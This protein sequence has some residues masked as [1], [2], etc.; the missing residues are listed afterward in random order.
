MPDKA[1]RLPPT[2]GGRTGTEMSALR[3]WAFL[4]KH[5]QV[6]LA[7]AKRPGSTVSDLA[8]ATEIT[9]RS[10]Y[11]VLADLQRSG[12]I[13]RR[14]MGRHN[15]YEIDPTMPLLDPTVENEH[16]RDLLK[17]TDDETFEARLFRLVSA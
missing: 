3:S 9:V 2:E 4:T 12:Y 11:R 6:L 8:D 17:L 7:I 10:T 13:R 16:V 1:T 15:T 5:A 14:K